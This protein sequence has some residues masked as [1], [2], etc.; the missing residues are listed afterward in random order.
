MISDGILIGFLELTMACA[1]G[2]SSLRLTIRA[3]DE[4]GLRDPEAW[5]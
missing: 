5:P 2:R 4:T 1:S 3:S